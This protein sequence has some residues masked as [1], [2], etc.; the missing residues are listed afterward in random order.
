VQG[1]P[2]DRHSYCDHF[3][4][5]K[6]VPVYRLDL[7]TGV[8]S[9]VAAILSK[10]AEMKRTKIM[11]RADSGRARAKTE[12]VKFGRPLAARPERVRELRSQ[13]VSI[14]EVAKMLNIG[15]ETVESLQ[16]LD[17]ETK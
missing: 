4:E 8:G 3:N 6:S 15:T 14:S 1:V 5:N 11:E 17:V 13:G 7:S 12:G 9:L 10:I 2:G 16:K